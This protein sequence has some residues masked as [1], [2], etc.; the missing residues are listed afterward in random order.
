M[1][2]EKHT[3]WELIND[4]RIEIPMI[5]RDYTYGRTDS[6]TEQIMRTFVGILVDRLK[7]DTPLHLDFIYG[8][9]GGKVNL[10]QLERNKHAISNLLKSVQAYSQTLDISVGFSLTDPVIE[11]KTG[12]TFFIPLDGQQRLTTLFLLHWYISARCNKKQ[13]ALGNFTYRTRKSS[14]DF[15]SALVNKGIIADSAI[16]VDEQIKN[17]PWFFERWSKDPTVKSMLVVLREIHNLLHDESITDI[18]RMWV[19]LTDNG[20]ISFAFLDTDRLTLTD[21]LYVKMNARG[22][23]LTDFENFKAWLQEYARK[24]EFDIEDKDW[25][26]KLD[27]EWTD[28][29][30][31]YKKS[32]E[33]N[34]DDAYLN[35]FRLMGLS[36]FAERVSIVNGELI[37]P[38]REVVDALRGS[39]FVPFETY[40]NNQIF[41][42]HV[43]DAIFLLLNF[44][45]HDGDR[46][47]VERIQNAPYRDVNDNIFENLLGSDNGKISLWTR[48]FL[49]AIFRFILV[50]GKPVI[51]YDVNDIIQMHQW[52]RVSSNL[53]YNTTIDNPTLLMNAISAI[54]SLSVHCLDIYTHLSRLES[55]LPFFSSAQ[56]SEERLK[57]KLILSDLNWEPIFIQFEGHSY[58]YGQINFLLELS[59]E[60]DNYDL[61]TFCYYAERAAAVFHPDILKHRDF[62]LQRALLVHGVYLVQSGRNYSLLLTDD[63][64]LRLREENWRRFFRDKGKQSILKDL[65][66][67]VDITDVA[68]S[69]QDIIKNAVLTG[70]RY[71]L[72]NY[73]IVFRYC[74]QK[75]LQW[76]EINT[77]PDYVMMLGSSKR[78]GYH[79]ELNSYCY[80]TEYLKG[81][82]QTFV[83]F[84]QVEYYQVKGSKE[85]PCAYLDNW[86]FQG[87]HFAIDIYFI[88]KLY[89]VAFFDRNEKVITDQLLRI[90]ESQ[91]FTSEN[92]RLVKYLNNAQEVNGIIINLCNSFKML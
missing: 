91:G 26:K 32:G 12:T 48:V 46:I 92:E 61:G 77:M 70:W 8:R 45:G 2:D 30:W 40:I 49:H 5:Q 63:G 87:S 34:I 31:G 44:L 86:F 16:P 56:E 50:K 36:F 80:Y 9:I 66:D 71:Y 25:L 62:L 38:H 4:H 52:V 82:A 15:C 81:N 23:Q 19:S 27:M 85:Y 72:V 21:E 55:R 69:L 76:P 47:I 73:P 28:L 67:G 79:C 24:E 51:S 1:P 35:F 17:A 10:V 3:F 7:S 65:I 29:L 39:G 75:L 83:P 68:G 14:K 13:E 11:K 42:K 43:L 89:K 37:P 74:V 33:F 20:L 6:K 53:V 84:K 54:N 41:Q 58:F 22:K 78:S 60:G 90:M 18:S 57:C 64:T 59:K 88:N